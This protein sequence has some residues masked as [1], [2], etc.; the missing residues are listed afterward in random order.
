MYRNSI[1][2]VLRFFEK[3]HGPDYKIYNLCSEKSYDYSKFR[4][5]SC[6]PFDD[7]NPPTIELIQDF[8]KD[9]QQF[10]CENVKHVAAVHCK[11]GKGRTGTMICCY[12]LHDRQFTKAEEAL[13]FYGQQRTYD[14]NGVTIPSQRRYVEY[15]ARLLND[16]L[17][18]EHIRLQILEIHLISP[19]P[20]AI[21]MEMVRIFFAG[22]R[23]HSELVKVSQ[24][25][26]TNANT[27]T[28]N[29]NLT[30]PPADDQHIV[31]QLCQPVVARAECQI[32]FYHK[33]SLKP[34]EKLFHFW[35]NTFFVNLSHNQGEF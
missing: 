8:C 6:F 33:P 27:T 17:P 13:N 1:D 28:T 19:P 11:A 32:Q 23:F 15:Y 26:A 7:H 10:L 18:Y 29:T 20:G 22:Q 14:K 21:N 12:L 4:R 9:V 34:K 16:R 5:Y 35:F 3:K 25:S 2:D 24:N 30:N 31:L